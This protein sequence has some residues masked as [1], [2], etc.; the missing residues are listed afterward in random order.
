MTLKDKDLIIVIPAH[1]EEKNLKIVINRFKKFSQTLIVNDCSNDKTK[2]ISKKYADFYL[3][4]K[5]KLGYDLS[6]RKGIKYVLNNLSNKEFILTCDADGQHTPDKLKKLLRKIKKPGCSIV[7]ASR[8]EFNRF[9]EKLV[10]IFSRI[11]LN[12]RDPYTGM[13]VYKAKNIKNEFMKLSIKS[14][15]I[16]LFFLMICKNNEIEEEIISTKVKNKASSFGN[17]IFINIKLL[18]IFF[19]IYFINLLKK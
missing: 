5:K 10:S 9:S 13:K 2:K 15:T 14:D 8:K 4:N 17:G 3:E 11:F 18:Y 12:I 16:G 19:K 7:I 1:N 6:L